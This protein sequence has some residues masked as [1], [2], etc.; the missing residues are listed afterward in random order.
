MLVCG[1][2]E[3]MVAFPYVECPTT[4]ISN[5][6]SLVNE[7]PKNWGKIYVSADFDR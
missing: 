1:R 4:R 3:R 2:K 7:L 5:T 6:Q